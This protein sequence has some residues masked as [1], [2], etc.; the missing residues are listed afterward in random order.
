MEHLIVFDLGGVLVPR[1][2]TLREL[3]TVMI[4]HANIQ[5]RANQGTQ[6]TVPTIITDPFSFEAAYGRYRESY[7]L[8]MGPNDYFTTLCRAAGVQPTPELIAE[9]E[10]T[11]TRLCSTISDSV[12]NL[13][14][15]L[16]AIDQPWGVF[17]NAPRPVMEAVLRQDWVD[18]AA[19]TCF[20]PDLR[21]TKPHQGAFRR[22][23][24]AAA[25]AGHEYATLIYFDDRQANLEAAERRGWE[26]FPWRG[27]ESV[28]QVLAPITSL[29]LAD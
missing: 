22:F 25:A 14:N 20:S 24:Q 13:L 18:G 10:E 21:F 11:D 8:S 16:N 4:R 1:R 29:R 19:V 17:S 26:A 28:H 15:H 2:H 9:L 12:R 3:T 6:T 5:S 23:E 7:S 27:V